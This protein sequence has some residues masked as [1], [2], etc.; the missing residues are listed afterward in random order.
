MDRPHSKFTMIATE[1][2]SKSTGTAKVNANKNFV[3]NVAMVAPQTC[4]AVRV[5]S[6]SSE[7]WIPKASEKASAIAIV[8]IPAR[9]TIL[10]CVPE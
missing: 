2:E 3:R 7:M 8:R 6:D 5:L 4:L 10:E 1:R 9:T